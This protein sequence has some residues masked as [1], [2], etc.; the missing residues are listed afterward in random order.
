VSEAGIRVVREALAAVQSRDADRFAALIARDAELRPLRAQ[1]EATDYRGPDGARRMF[2]D[3]WAQ[4]QEFEFHPE[5]V[6]AE[7]A[8]VVLVGRLHTR[9]ATSGAAIDTTV[10]WRFHLRDGQIELGFSYSDP[11]DAFRES[12]IGPATRKT[13][14]AVRRHYEAFNTNDIDT[15]VATL[16]PE[17]EISGGDERAAGVP[18]RYRGLDEARDFFAGIKELVADNV[19]EVLTLEATESLVVASVRLHGTFRESGRTGSI[20]A[21]HFLT[22]REDLV[23]RIET[24]R[25]NWRREAGADQPSRDA[26][27]G[28]TN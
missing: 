10:G 11:A 5:E 19:V 7:G 2:A 4:W 21:V 23:A 9:G 18:E 15:I 24:Y 27:S 22:V 8:T 17:I 28:A 6:H 25:P 1:L 20:P 12:G 13:V 3:W 26:R 14:A 16:H